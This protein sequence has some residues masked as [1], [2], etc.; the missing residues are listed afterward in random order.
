MLFMTNGFMAHWGFWC[1]FEEQT[2][3]GTEQDQP[4]CSALAA[5]PLRFVYLA[6]CVA[7]HFDYDVVRQD[8][9]T[10]YTQFIKNGLVVH[11]EMFTNQVLHYKDCIAQPKS[12]F[13]SAII[14]SNKGNAK[15]LSSLLNVTF[16]PLSLFRYLYTVTF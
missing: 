16:K 10:L 14:D 12:N 4:I 11:K 5:D 8:L 9:R 13:Y 15:S 6:V 1:T 3:L 7:H 2:G